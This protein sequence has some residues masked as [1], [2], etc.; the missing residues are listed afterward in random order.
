VGLDTKGT[1]YGIHATGLDPA[2]IRWLLLT[3]AHA[4]HAGGAAGLQRA[5]PGLR[6]AAAAQA[7]PWLRAANEV[8]MSLDFARRAG[9]YPDDYRMVPCEVDRELREGDE[10]VVGTLVLRVIETPGH[11]TGHLSF[12]MRDTGQEML[13]GG[14]HIFHGGKVSIQNIPDCDLQAYARSTAKLAQLEIDG[15]LPGHLAPSL[16]R[17]QR[18]I[19]SAHRA[20][21]RLGVPRSIL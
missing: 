19:A 17:G 21:Q 16:K 6:V 14:D 5:L 8:A 10:V 2:R 15:L 3:H 18:H 11:C 9:L 4:D 13:F 20:F 7:A 12:L 1:L